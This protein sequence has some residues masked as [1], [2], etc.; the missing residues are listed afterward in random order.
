MK[1]EYSS[2]EV[3]SFCGVTNRMLQWWAE[4]DVLTPIIEGHKRLYSYRELLLAWTI[5]EMK[6]AGLSLQKIRPCLR[7][8]RRR[9]R[10]DIHDYLV[11]DGDT[12]ISCWSPADALLAMQS[13][14]R[15]RRHGILIN[16]SEVRAK[17]RLA[18][19]HAA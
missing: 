16:L 12:V 2:A 18:H 13:I 3:A 14:Q 11:I 9:V 17:A 5:S 8:L 7:T 1:T 15:R 10:D 19:A 4:R 6:R